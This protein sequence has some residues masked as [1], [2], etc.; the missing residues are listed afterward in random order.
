MADAEA[1]RKEQMDLEVMMF[2]LGLGRMEELAKD[3][4]RDGRRLRF[5][6]QSTHA[7]SGP[8]EQHQAQAPRVVMNEA[9]KGWNGK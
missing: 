7:P 4:S 5:P 2:D 3:D 6:M 9:A 1:K 8:P